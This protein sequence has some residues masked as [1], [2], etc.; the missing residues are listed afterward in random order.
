M[1]IQKESTLE[2]LEPYAAAWDRLA[3]DAP[4][5]VPM[6]SHAWVSS[7]LE[8]LLRP[9]DPWCCL[10]AFDG[11]EL[12]GVLPV[13]GPF[14]HAIMGECFTAPDNVDVRVGDLLAAEGREAEVV[15]ALLDHLMSDPGFGRLRLGKLLPDSPALRL[16]EFMPGV[17]VFAEPDGHGSFI[18]IEGS[19]EAHL[20]RLSSGF[21][22]NLKRAKKKLDRLDKVE[23]AYLSGAAAGEEHI[24]PFF[25]LEGS[26]WK[27]REGSAILSSERHTAFFTALARRLARAGLLEWHFLTLDGALLA[28]HLAA[29]THRKVTLWKVA[30]DERYADCAPGKLLLLR[31]IERSYA[32]GDI[33]EINQVSD[34]DW[35]RDWRMDRRP[36]VSLE[37]S[38]PR[39]VPRMYAAVSVLARTAT[40]AARQQVKSSPMLMPL[41][42]RVRGLVAGGR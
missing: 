13:I 28:G 22:N 27:G 36:Y 17:R 6:L 23:E 24:R 15:P 16:N 18:R 25:E 40:K 3:H 10:L 35:H 14:R 38:S 8:H 32:S 9:D 4:Q 30:Y 2:G 26:G 29:R 21:R 1:R 11:A 20:A 42:K 31:L 7:F 37:V 39:V 19:Y 5:G 41:V 34:Q 33:D 12:V